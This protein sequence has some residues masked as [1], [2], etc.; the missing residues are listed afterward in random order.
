MGQVLGFSYPISVIRRFVADQWREFTPVKLFSDDSDLILF[1]FESE[2][3]CQA[4]LKQYWFINNSRPLILRPWE[5]G[6]KIENFKLDTVPIWMRLSNIPFDL[7]T[8][9]GT[10]S[11]GSY[12][13]WT[14][15]LL[16]VICSTLLKL[17]LR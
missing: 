17:M 11:I 12:F 6:M 7:W 4:A 3:S 2:A 1:K 13:L 10:S 8:D 16:M 14:P 15:L 9:D 5:P